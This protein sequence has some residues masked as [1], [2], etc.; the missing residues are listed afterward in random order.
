MG[1]TLEIFAD[2][3]EGAESR[4]YRDMGQLFPV[5]GFACSVGP[6]RKEAFLLT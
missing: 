4:Y 3:L 6:E 1:K 5:C 2:A